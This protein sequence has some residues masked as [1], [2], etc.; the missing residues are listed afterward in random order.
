MQKI[1]GLVDE[2]NISILGPP[3]GRPQS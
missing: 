2:Y 1:M 3:P